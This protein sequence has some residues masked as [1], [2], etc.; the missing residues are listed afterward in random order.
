M[1]NRERIEYEEWRVS[2]GYK[3]KTTH[4]CTKCGMINPSWKHMEETCPNLKERAK[5]MPK[6]RY[7]T[8][9][10]SHC[11]KTGLWLERS[12]KRNY[13]NSWQTYRELKCYHCG[14]VEDEQEWSY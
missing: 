7:D 8:I 2:E 12:Y 5:A 9:P 10:C 1:M 4:I 13:D 6:R 3:K 14:N 11:G